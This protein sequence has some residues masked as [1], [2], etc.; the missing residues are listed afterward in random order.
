VADAA[1]DYLVVVGLPNAA[2]PA[3]MRHVHMAKLVEP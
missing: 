3:V 2:A 1:A